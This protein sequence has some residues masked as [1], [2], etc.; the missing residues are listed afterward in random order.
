MNIEEENKVK[1]FYIESNVNGVHTQRTNIIELN[2]LDMLKL[3]HS[4]AESKVKNLSLCSVVKSSYC[5]AVNEHEGKCQQQCLGCSMKQRR[6][7]K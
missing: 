7:E 6:L 4:Y 2:Y 3:M 1:Q 5:Y